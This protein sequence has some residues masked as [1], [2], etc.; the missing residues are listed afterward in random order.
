MNIAPLPAEHH[1]PWAACNLCFSWWWHMHRWWCACLII[2]AFCRHQWT[3]YTL[4]YRCWCTVV[5]LI[6]VR[7][8]CW[9][10]ETWDTWLLSQ[11]L[12]YC[13]EMWPCNMLTATYSIVHKGH[14]ETYTTLKTVPNAW[15][16]RP[17]LDLFP[18]GRNISSYCLW[19][20][21]TQNM[22]CVLVGFCITFSYHTQ[23]TA[24]VK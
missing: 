11:C 2:S 3:V 19:Q 5:W 16:F 12:L 21:I 20:M 14:A 22:F 10:C 7:L 8:A 1:S 15:G 17:V 24:V 6:T 23:R 13:G 18:N 9:P 4:L